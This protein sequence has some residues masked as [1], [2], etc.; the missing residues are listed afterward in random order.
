MTFESAF[1]AATGRPVDPDALDRLAKEAMRQ[2][3]EERALPLFERAVTKA[4]TARLWQ[5]KGLLERS[6]DEH[7]AAL[8]SFAEAA[9]LD[10]ADVSIAHG[11]ARVAMEAG[12]DAVELYRQARALAP[13]NGQILIGLAAAMAARGEGERAVEELQKAVEGSPMWL[14]GHEQLAQFVAT[15]G[16]PDEATD[17]LE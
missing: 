17:S 15:V 5:W 12:V 11:R 6:I 13:Q 3:E 8:A 10:P 14:A 7:E 9:K 4:P 2:G 1:A 16:R